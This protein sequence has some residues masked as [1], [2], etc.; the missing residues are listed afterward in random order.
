M[1]PRRCTVPRLGWWSTTA[2]IDNDPLAE[3]DRDGLFTQWQRHP[4]RCDR[5]RAYALTSPGHGRSLAAMIDYRTGHVTA[6]EPAGKWPGAE[7][8]G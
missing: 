1:R 7:C 3:D 8:A 5:I 4:S 6:E 2:S